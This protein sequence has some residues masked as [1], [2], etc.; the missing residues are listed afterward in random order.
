MIL[1]HFVGVNLANVVWLRISSL[2]APPSVR[3]GGDPGSTLLIVTLSRLPDAVVLVGQDTRLQLLALSGIS[4]LLWAI[5]EA[6][7]D[8]RS[9][10][11]LWNQRRLYWLVAFTIE[12]LGL[13]QLRG[14]VIK[15][16]WPC[17]LLLAHLSGERLLL[18]PGFRANSVTEETALASVLL[19]EALSSGYVFDGSSKHCTLPSSFFSNNWGPRL[20]LRGVISAQN[21]GSSP[22]IGSSLLDV[23]GGRHGAW[24]HGGRV[25]LIAKDVRVL[26]GLS[27]SAR[28]HWISLELSLPSFIVLE[29][30]LLWRVERV[31]CDAALKGSGL[32]KSVAHI[33]WLDFVSQ[34]ITSR[35]L[36]KFSSCVGHIS[37]IFLLI[38]K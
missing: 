38:F 10:F 21:V 30:C 9:H 5:I 14:S 22:S 2:R 7:S 16:W 6:V 35:S 27:C 20:V 26:V 36:I 29:C 23:L 18:L 34:D 31:E 11:L 1:L 32:P 37:S 25:G 4:V 28:L 17:L 24:L 3:C 8:L 15:L 12:L 13:S 19:C 33:G